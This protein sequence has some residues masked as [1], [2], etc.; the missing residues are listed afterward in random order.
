[1]EAKIESKKKS[2]WL[3]ISAFLFFRFFI[4]EHFA[5]P[6]CS[7]T[8]TLLTGD[9]ILIKKYAY[10]AS[11]QSLPF[12]GYLPIWKTGIRFGQPQYADIAVFTL[13]RDPATYYVKRIVGL[14][15]DT[16]Q[17]KDGILHINGKKCGMKFVAPFTFRSDAGKWETGK[18]FEIEIPFPP[19]RKYVVYRDKPFGQGHV[20]NTP[21]FKIPP[22]H[23]WVQGDYNSGSDDSFN[24]H[25]MGPI[26]IENLSGTVFFV[27][28][29]TNSRLPAEQS[30]AKW[31]AQLP[32]RIFVALKETNFSRICI[33]V[34]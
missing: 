7:M 2:S 15:G 16:V 8:S 10:A 13:P 6:S 1:M 24:P 4:I 9:I 5:V 33:S 11:R 12:G 26:P 25:F 29:G 31:V 27:L 20:D 19:H 3:F 14:P 32:W 21:V 23:V 18:N 22:G 34:K 28:Y 30:W 17:M